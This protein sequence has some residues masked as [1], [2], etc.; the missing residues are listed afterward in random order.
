MSKS[1]WGSINVTELVNVF[2]QQHSA[3]AMVGQSKNVFVSVILWENDK[4]DRHGCTHALK[5]RAAKNSDDKNIYIARLKPT[6]VKVSESDA[7][8]L[9][10]DYCEDLAKREGV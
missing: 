8:N 2:N 9:D 6:T 3:F 7:I 4:P 10:A 5:I 1:Y